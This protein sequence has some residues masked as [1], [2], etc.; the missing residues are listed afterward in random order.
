L[1]AV[2]FAYGDLRVATPVFVPAQPEFSL[3]SS[4]SLV[5]PAEAGIQLW[6][7]LVVIP[8]KAGI[9]LDLAVFEVQS[10]VSPSGS[11]LLS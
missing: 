5:I 9:H 1:Q 3:C 10:F 6:L 11:R 4:S 8:A 7:F 2:T